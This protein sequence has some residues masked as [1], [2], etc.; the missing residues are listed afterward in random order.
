MT[1]FNYIAIDSNGKK[2]R[3][4]AEADSS[5]AL[6]TQLKKQAITIISAERLADKTKTEKG[7]ARSKL[8]LSGKIK[9]EDLVVFFRQ[10]ATMVDAG[11]QLVDGLSILTDQAENKSLR[12]ILHNVR[13]NVEGGINFSFALARHPHVFPN[14]AISMVKVAEASGNLSGILEQ[15]ATYI[16]DKDKI[17]RKIKS[18]SSY[19][20][21]ILIFFGLVVSAVIFGLVPKFKDIFESFGAQLP[22][23]TLVILAVSNFVRRNFFIEAGLLAGLVVGF[24][25]FTSKPNGRRFLHQMYFKLPIIG[26]M[27]LKSTIARFTKTLGTLTK[28]GVGLVDAIS[29]AAE[30]T[31]NLVIQE[32]AE[33]VKKGVTGGASLA[34]SLE[35]HPL[36]PPMMTK[37]IAVGEESGA[38]E[39][40]LN[41]VAEF[42]ERQLNG[43]IDSL[44]AII[45]PVLMIGL[46]VLALVVVIAL[47]LPI[48]QM[49]GAIGG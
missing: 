21:F 43:M 17:D 28:N 47:Y 26:K 42:Y 30:T 41:K 12:D 32:I 45:E 3:G 49:S 10:L 23:P 16:E 40:M 29:I 39:T 13:E 44:T 36:F 20:R 1:Y 4:T 18:A 7:L 9:T 24:K 5:F 38:L 46:G 2:I 11:V 15:L 37:M 31:N 48:F 22:G 33:Q 14:I 8:G 19:P 35:N 6:A 27:V 25:I 34:R